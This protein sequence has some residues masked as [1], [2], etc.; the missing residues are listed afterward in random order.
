MLHGEY[1]MICWLQDFFKNWA[2]A[3]EALATV[4]LVIAAVFQWTTMRAQAKQERCRW[5]REDAIRAEENRPKAAFGF[6]D[7]DVPCNLKL[8]CANLGTVGFLI[9]GMQIFPLLGDSQKILFGKGAEIFVPVGE[10]KQVTFDSS[11]YRV[12]HER[13]KHTL[14]GSLGRHLG[15]KLILQGPVE[16]AQTSLEAYRVHQYPDA[17]GSLYG[18]SSWR[19]ISDN[20]GALKYE[21]ARC[22]RCTN[23]CT[24]DLV[25]DLGVVFPVEGCGTVF[26]TARNKMAAVVRDFDQTCPNHASS[27]SRVTF[28][29]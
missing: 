3:V 24:V 7:N 2:V 14:G 17:G 22:P 23:P 12:V 1:S 4:A 18:F 20:S 27:N 10:E 21:Y 8:S 6:S 25:A 29:T 26:A 15:I 19:M 5:K 11:N 13:L 16:T 28:G 9:T